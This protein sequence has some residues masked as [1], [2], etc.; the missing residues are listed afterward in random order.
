[1]EQS[2]VLQPTAFTLQQL[3]E[4]ANRT[5]FNLEAFRHHL[6]SDQENVVKHEFCGADVLLS[7]VP[8]LRFCT[9]PQEVQLLDLF[10][11]LMTNTYTDISH[12]A[13]NKNTVSFF[14]GRFASLE[15]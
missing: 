9:A 3:H 12:N 8:A 4:W 15:L 7:D 6:Q 2:F 10:L 11:F 14:R 5:N 1:M 13:L